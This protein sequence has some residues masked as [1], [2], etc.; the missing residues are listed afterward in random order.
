MSVI[1]IPTVWDW[2]RLFFT[3]PLFWAGLVVVAVVGVLW[4]RRVRKVR[5]WW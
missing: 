1:I 4:F 5:G 3:D 2:F